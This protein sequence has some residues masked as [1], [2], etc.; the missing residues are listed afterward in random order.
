[1]SDVLTVA[2]LVA[3]SPR[4]TVTEDGKHV[5]S[6]RLASPRLNFDR[7][8]SSWVDEGTNWYT[9]HTFGQLAEN[10]MAS[11][12]KGDRVIVS[13]NLRV[14]DWGNAEHKGTNVEL[15]ATAVGHD[16]NHGT[17]VF[18]RTFSKPRT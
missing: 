14:I 3:T 5:A 9:V 13:G 16:L 17:A 12:G 6:L 2:G 18:K 7:E 1:M 8:T 11:I 4:Q 15:V 10:V